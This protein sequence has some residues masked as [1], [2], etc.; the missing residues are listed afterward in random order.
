MLRVA[1]VAQAL[2]AAGLF[3]VAVAQVIEA[4]SG[5]SYRASSAVGL[6]V[7]EAITVALIA[8]IASGITRGRPWSRTPGIMTQLGCGLLAI[9]LLQAHR[10]DVGVPTLVLAIA[11]LAGLLHPASLKALARPRRDP[12]EAAP[13]PAAPSAGRKNVP[14]GPQ[15]NAAAKGGKKA[16]SP[17]SGKKASPASGR[18]SA[19]RR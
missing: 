12:A 11:G 14:A 8:W 17:A 19:A 15:P 16:A 13:A 18:K 3:A 6:A 7:M 4:A 2:E 1:A 10:A 9:I 5:Q